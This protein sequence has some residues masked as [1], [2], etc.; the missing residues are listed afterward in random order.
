MDSTIGPQ[1]SAD[2]IENEKILVH[3]MITSLDV[4][5]ENYNQDKE[6][7]ES[8]LRYYEQLLRIKSN[9]ATPTSARNPSLPTSATLPS[10]SR[11]S[12]PNWAPREPSP[13]DRKTIEGTL[14]PR[15][16]SLDGYTSESSNGAKK[17]PRQDSNLTGMP[18]SSKFPRTHHTERP[19]TSSTSNSWGSPDEELLAFGG[20]SKVRSNGTFESYMRRAQ[21]EEER[22]RREQADQELARQLSEQAQA[23]APPSSSF[24]TNG[25]LNQ[26]YIAA[27]GTYA[28]PI[29]PA[30]PIKQEIPAYFGTTLAGDANYQHNL[31]SSNTN[32]QPNSFSAPAY[33]QPLDGQWGQ[34]DEDDDDLQIITPEQFGA[35]T[36]AAAHG[37]SRYQPRGP[38][39]YGSIPG[40]FPHASYADLNFS[41]QEYQSNP[42]QSFI[43]SSSNYMGASALSLGQQMSAP[44]SNG[45]SAAQG[46][47]PSVVSSSYHGQAG[48]S[49]FGDP[50]VNNY[51]S[52]FDDEGGL[53]REVLQD[54]E[55]RQMGYMLA[56][57]T[58]T[59]EDIVQLLEN[60]R[61]DEELPPELREGGPKDLRVQ[62]M[63][64]QKLGLA[65]MKQK[66]ESSNKGSILADDMGLGK[67]IQ[68]RPFRRTCGHL[69]RPSLLMYAFDLGS[70]VDPRSAFSKSHH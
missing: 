16:L 44:V 17:R 37:R 23:H 60:I 31:G 61:P 58:K 49:V 69:L 33:V 19:A 27:D 43:H 5:D 18:S 22:W 51:S 20:Q 45:W 68:V 36:S 41:G 40:S 66:E 56:D 47:D 64:H 12:I 6:A 46:I 24:P 3:V 52:T 67:T 13:S 14:D 54:L 65:W 1:S 42:G 25:A 34:V 21:R 38:V 9:S 50:T 4:H 55:S 15:A 11:P 30:V 57:P 7:L 8:K 10:R 28:R 62:L 48:S 26:S 63:E 59:K 39:N 29:P 53:S 2:D 35:R 70:C 32:F